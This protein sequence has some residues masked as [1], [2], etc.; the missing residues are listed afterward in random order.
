MTAGSHAS[1]NKTARLA[2]ALY[3]AMAVFGFF[4]IL[5]VPS[6]LVVPGDAAT[7]A[8][9]IMASEG[10]FR[11]GTVSHLIG[12]TIFIFLVLALYRLLKPVD[13]NRAVL[14]V[15]LALLGVPIA[16]LNEVHHLGALR[17]LSSADGGGFTP[18]QLQVQA[19]RFLDMRRSGILLNQVFWGLWLLPLGLLILRSGFLPKLLGIL[20]VIGGVGYVVDWATQLLWPSLPTISQFTFLGELLLPLWLLIKGVNV[21]RWQEAALQAHH[22]AV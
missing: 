9:N 18:T 20:L 12:Q 5:Y 4:G 21:A 22:G 7:T 16:F 14:M 15:L 6:V 13:K 3:L 17:L 8:R 19:M 2:G 1:I 11:S 10:L